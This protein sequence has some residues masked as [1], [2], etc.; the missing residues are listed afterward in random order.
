MTLR[1]VVTAFSAARVCYGTGLAVAPGLFASLWIGS[2]ARD[3]RTQ[4]MA[5][6]LGIRD[7]VLGGGGLLA[8]RRSDAGRPRWWF[9]AQAASDTVDGLATLAAGSEFP[10]LVR[11]ALAGGA[12]ASAAV[13]AVAAVREPEAKP[14]LDVVTRGA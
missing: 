2:G 3:P 7:L 8:M 10:R 5:R 14:Q 12:F 13:A 4:M 11:T 1:A 6:G 9:A